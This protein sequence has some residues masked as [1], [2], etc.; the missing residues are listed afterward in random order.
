[1]FRTSSNVS[2]GYHRLVKV[3]TSLAYSNE[4]KAFHEFV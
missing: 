2:L 1:M 3:V 4:P